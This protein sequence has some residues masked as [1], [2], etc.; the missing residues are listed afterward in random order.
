MHKSRP[1]LTVVFYS[2]IELMREGAK[3]AVAISKDLML[4]AILTEKKVPHVYV[5]VDGGMD[6]GISVK[7]RVTPGVGI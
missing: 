3:Q 6:T 5:R 7:G 1:E 2:S 4:T